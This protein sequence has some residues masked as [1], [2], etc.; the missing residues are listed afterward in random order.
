MKCIQLTCPL[1][2]RHLF[3]SVCFEVDSNES[4]STVCVAK[5]PEGYS[6]NTVDTRIISEKQYELSDT[7]D[8]TSLTQEYFHKSFR[9][10]QKVILT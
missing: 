2:L 6:Y 10:I 4:N 3:V 7:I 8:I 5:L 9:N 1:I